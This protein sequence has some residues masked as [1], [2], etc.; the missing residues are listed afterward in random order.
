MSDYSSFYTTPTGTAGVSVF[1]A[2]YYG[3]L[4]VFVI[5]LILVFVHFTVYPIFALTPNDPGI[6]VVSGTSDR[7][8]A[9]TLND[10]NPPKP[11]NAR[12]KNIKRTTLPPCTYT[13]GVDVYIDDTIK[14]QYPL[15]IFYRARAPLSSTDAA[16]PRPLSEIYTDTNIIAWC[17]PDTKEVQVALVTTT[18]DGTTVQK[19][20]D[21]AYAPPNKKTF[22]L[23]I[24]VADSFAEVYINGGL[25]STINAANAL[26]SISETDFYPPVVE[27]GVG[28]VSIG[29]M[30]MWPRLLTSKE[31]RA[32]ESGPMGDLTPPI[33]P[34]T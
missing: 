8:L 14:T 9:Y 19:S 17:Q 33:I 6:I 21:R 7:E 25:L 22:R 13:L 18:S 29:N 5:F 31:I 4:S 23:T 15:P 12:N 30:A 27:H 34:R 11:E 20:M 32:Y 10:G 3:S 26:K 2:L 1:G 16:A 24:V 28:G